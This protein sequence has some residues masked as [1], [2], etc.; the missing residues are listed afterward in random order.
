MIEQQ[1][2][3]RFR[4][5]VTDEPPL[6]FDPDDVI[7]RA[8]K[9]TRRRRVVW[10][11]AAATMVEAVAVWALAS[12]P[13]SAGHDQ[14]QAGG[15]PSGSAPAPAEAS[16]S[17][18]PGFTFRMTAFEATLTLDNPLAVRAAEEEL[19]V[20]ELV[21]LNPDGDDGS[22]Q[23][24][25]ADGVMEEISLHSM[26]RYNSKYPQPLTAEPGVPVT[27]AVNCSQSA[28]QCRGVSVTVSGYTIVRES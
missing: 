24:K 18:A 6:G 15:Q 2:A 21:V 23:L 16:P 27:L 12:T 22:I 19:D 5:A 11:V 17:P 10:G 1:V 4:D 14:V 25:R 3:D 8:I 9:R 13:G 28:H 7:D 26:S 20:H